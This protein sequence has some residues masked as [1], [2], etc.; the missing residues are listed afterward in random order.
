MVITIVSIFV[1]FTCCYAL[2]AVSEDNSPSPMFKPGT[3]V[4]IVIDPR[5]GGP[6]SMKNFCL[7]HGLKHVVEPNGNIEYHCRR[8]VHSRM[9]QAQRKTVRN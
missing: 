9:M 4:P 6:Y 2:L 3:R 5:T 8:M 1:M 7:D